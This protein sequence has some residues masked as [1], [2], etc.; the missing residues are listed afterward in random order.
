MQTFG[1]L[2]WLGQEKS[3]ANFPFPGKRLTNFH[4]TSERL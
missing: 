3:W 1:T 2:S 4:M